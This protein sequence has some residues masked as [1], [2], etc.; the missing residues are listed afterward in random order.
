MDTGNWADV[1]VEDNGYENSDDERIM[2][3]TARSISSSSKS[4]SKST[5]S[6][7]NNPSSSSSSTSSSKSNK[8]KKNS[9][10]K[11]KEKTST[12][13]TTSTSTST[14]TVKSS[15]PS[16]QPSKKKP[17]AAAA[18]VPLKPVAQREV[19]FSNIVFVAQPVVVATATTAATSIPE[20]LSTTS[21]TSTST[22]ASTATSENISTT[23]PPPPP[24]I[25]ATQTKQHD[26]LM[27]VF[28]HF[29]VLDSSIEVNWQEHSCTVVYTT[30]GDANKAVTAFKSVSHLE[31][32]IGALQ[33]KHPTMAINLKSI[34]NIKAAIQPAPKK[35]IT[36]TTPS[37]TLRQSTT[38][39]PTPTPPPKNL[40]S[41]SRN[42]HPT[43]RAPRG[44]QRS[45]G[46][47]RSSTPSNK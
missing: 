21:T 24:Y 35:D 42:H 1:E 15:S 16:T 43:N 18:P 7:N 36:S 44:E 2:R 33:I 32:V 34:W 46:F 19:T 25:N 38:T 41:S 31:D 27:L 20:G 11:E 23:S 17:A 22:D 14:S 6:N 3:S 37:T 45:S 28:R 9:K 8:K 29:G 10:S 5:S 13:S 12:T 26:E 39:H 47:S 40:F 30:V 4:T